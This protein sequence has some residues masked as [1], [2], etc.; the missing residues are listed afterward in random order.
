MPVSPKALINPKLLAV[1]RTSAGFSIEEVSQ[2]LR[3]SRDRLSNWESGRD[4][5]PIKTLRR[6]ARKYKRPTCFFYLPDLPA[7]YPELHDFRRLPADYDDIRSHSLDFEYRNVQDIRQEALDLLQLLGQE[8]QII[9]NTISL[10][11][12]TEEV[13][14]GFRK[15]LGID[16]S[17]Q[18]SWT[19]KYEALNEWRAAIERT[20]ILVIQVGGR[21][22]RT[23]PVSEMRGFSIAGPILPVIALNGK[24]SVFGRC[25]TLLHELA[26]ILLNRSGVC[27]LHSQRSNN[28]RNDEIEVYCNQIAGS[29]L[30]P[31]ESLLQTHVV[32]RHGTAV[33]WSEDELNILSKSYWVSTHV[34]IR[35]LLS[36]GKTSEEFYR[37]WAERFKGEDDQ[38]IT[39][40]DIRIPVERKVLK[41]LGRVF[42]ALIFNALSQ[43]VVSSIE[44]SMALEAN[45]N[46]F[47][48]ISSEVFFTR[49]SL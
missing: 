41:R 20:G 1:G 23:I 16:L 24:D 49:Y 33:A 42:P 37:Q 39:T 9:E 31:T 12:D 35:R 34:I 21:K 40:G 15:L 32:L 36:V 7:E 8:P 22:D 19:N 48:A 45:P 30:V 17:D 2:S 43:G 28:P 6:L 4:S 11:D 10:S 44:A 3:I 27:D 29:S 38:S 14:E 25:F 47:E 18:L 46:K 5:P 13:A 26:H